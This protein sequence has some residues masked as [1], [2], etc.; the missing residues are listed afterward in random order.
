MD[1]QA[2]AP[3]AEQETDLLPPERVAQL[4]LDSYRPREADRAAAD[5]QDL[6][7]ARRIEGDIPRDLAVRPAGARFLFISRDQRAYTHGLH[8]Y[9]AKFFPELP[10]WIVE[11]YSQPGELI[12]DPFMG[13]GT[14]NLEAMLRGRPSVGVD[15]DPFSRF[16]AR[17][18]T[19]PL[20]APD[21]AAAVADLTARLDQFDPAADVADIPEFPYRDNWF[22]PYVL[23]E[24]AFIQGGIAELPTAP[25]VKDFLRAVFFLGHPAS[26]PSR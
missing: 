6:P 5:V 23:R 25:A 21:L 8:K 20:P 12:L 2:V 13:S 14:T 9:P 24:L 26:V 10:R 4:A 17:A 11:R 15:I 18:K 1:L 7:P 3:A 22:K 19:T 16:L